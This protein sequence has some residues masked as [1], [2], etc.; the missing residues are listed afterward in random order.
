MARPEPKKTK[1]GRNDPCHCGSGKKYKDCHLPQEQAFRSEQ[2]RLREAQDLLLPKIFEAAQALPEAF[3]PAFALFWNERYSVEQMSELDEHE[4]RGAER[5]L[6]WFAFDYMPAGG[7]TLIEQLHAT[8]GRGEFAADE[9]E[10]H[11]LAQWQP[12]RLRPYQVTEVRKGRG[13]T[14]RDLLDDQ[15]YE[16]ADYG[17]SKRLEDGEV[18]VG[19]IVPV[20]RPAPDAAP[21]YY[22]AGAAAQLTADTAAKLLEF[23]ELYLADLR[24][25][26]PAATWADLLRQRSYVL[27]HFVMAL[28]REERDPTLVEKIIAD[29]RA[30]LQLTGESIQQLLGRQPSE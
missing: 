11:L 23:A 6:I 10:Q 3:A 30:S 1:L 19:H 18:V 4:D 8:A 26:D 12:V 7:V 9:L 13:V 2:M 14:L 17:A 21:I 25:S 16:V 28:P 5:F 20:D 24:R 22:L 27:N 29:G 15:Q